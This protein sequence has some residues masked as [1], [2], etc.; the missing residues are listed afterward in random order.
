MPPTKLP[1]PVIVLPGILGTELRDQYPVSADT[2][3]SALLNKDYDRITLHP[4]DLRYELT[5]PSRVT[6]GNPFDL[7]YGELIE[8]LRHE[9][10]PA[11]DRPVPV[12]PFGYDWR[13]P[14]LM[15][16]H[17]LASF[18]DEV[19]ARTSLLRHYVEDGYADDPRVSLV[20]HSMGGLIIAGYLALEGSA[21]KVHKVVS[22][23]TPFRGSFEAVL[24]V[25]TGTASIGPAPSSSREREAARLTPSLYHLVPSFPGGVVPGAAGVKTDLF[26][27][28]A[29]QPGVAATLS[30]FIRQHA[31][32]PPEAKKDLKKEA[33]DLLRVLLDGARSFINGVERLDLGALGMKPSQWLAIIGVDSTTRVRLRIDPGPSF[34]LTSE[35]RANAWGSKKAAEAELT[36]DGTVPFA[37]AVPT[38]LPRE[39]L[40]C[41]RPADF[42]YWEVADRAAVAVAGFHPILPK[43]NLA[44]RLI[45]S[46][47][48]DNRSTKALPPARNGTWARGA[49]RVPRDAWSPP[50]AGLAW[51]D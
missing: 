4:R 2:V 43:L 6:E 50:I 27:P 29:W 16:A 8:E 20:G 30:E 49:P 11:K 37:G 28:A 33:R 23:G 13:Q 38:F 18:V 42:G 31:P 9:L 19:I 46:F 17:R 3:W 21:S 39:S 35:D 34:D 10:S 32:D 1:H 5:E 12:F 45:A 36:G 7:P 14:L 22:L 47:L 44:H 40:V 24:K 15:T 41:V 51:K 48:L 25:A 26:D